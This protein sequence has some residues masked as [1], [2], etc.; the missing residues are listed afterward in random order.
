MKVYL[1]YTV[2]YFP[3]TK[4]VY[5][6][7]TQSHPGYHQVDGKERRAGD[8]CGYSGCA[9]PLKQKTRDSSSSSSQLQ[10]LQF[11][12]TSFL[13]TVFNTFIHHLVRH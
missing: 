10:S 4:D 13:T 1:F 11:I 12:T 7:Y 3:G 9:A 6:C 5:H 8:G 2:V